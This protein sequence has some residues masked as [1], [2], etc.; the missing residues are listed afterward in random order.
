MILDS[1]QVQYDEMI[2]VDVWNVHG[3]ILRERA[4]DY[5]CQVP[6]GA[7]VKQGLLYEIDDRHNMTIFKEQIV[8]FRQRMK[9]HGERNK[10]LILS[11]YGILFPIRLGFNEPRVQEFI[12]AAF[13]YARTATSS[14]LGYPADGDRLVQA[15][16]WYSLDYEYSEGYES[17][18]QLFDP[19]TEKITR[20]GRAY[21]DYTAFMP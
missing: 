19:D 7:T 14:S 13:D 10:P 21:G 16:A 15:W 18:N 11:E 17:Y 4:D 8:R 5:G 20:L 3:F 9:D 1:C 2:P 6:R 12:L